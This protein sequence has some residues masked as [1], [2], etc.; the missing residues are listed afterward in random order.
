MLIFK[1]STLLNGNIVFEYAD[2]MIVFISIDF[3]PV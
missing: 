1:V 3:G 2:Y